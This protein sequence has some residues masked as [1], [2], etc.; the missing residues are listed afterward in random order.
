MTNND[1]FTHMNAASELR[2]ALRSLGRAR[3][4]SIASVL[5]I[6]LGVAAGSMMYVL[7]YGVLFRPLPYPQSDQLVEL[8]HTFPGLG[9][10]LV[11]QAPGT[12][13]SYRRNATLLESI[14]SHTGTINI[15]FGDPV[16]G[17]QRV[18]ISSV[19]PSL[20]PMLRVRPLTGR[21]FRDSDVPSDNRSDYM[22][23]SERFWRSRLAADPNV[24]GK[25]FRVGD[26]DRTVIGVLP[27]AFQ[28]PSAEV[29][30][31]FP[32]E[33][34]PGAYLGAFGFQAIG[35]MRP[36][37]TLPALQ[38]QL[39][40]ILTHVP[41][42]FP[43]IHAG[44]GTRQALTQARAVPVVHTLLDDTIGDFGRVLAILAAIVATLIIVAMSNLTSLFLARGESRRRELAVRATLG[45]SYRRLAGG[46][47]VETTTLAIIGGILGF[48][49]AV[50]GIGVLRHTSSMSFISASQQAATA[51]SFHGSRRFIRAPRSRLRPSYSRWRS[52]S[53]RAPWAV[54]ASSRT[55]SDE[56]C[57]TAA[58]PELTRVPT[59]V[60]G[61]S[62]WRPK[63]RY[64]SCS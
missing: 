35:R 12:Y 17:A 6:A 11:P 54:G 28:F 53:S 62:S 30:I 36:D 7:I 16:D 19:T 40:Q 41:D 31:W 61:R 5:T 22:I 32:F 27:A 43:E 9:M 2:Y 1:A 56:F 14:A 45:A 24:L 48:A 46:V 49:L 26:A 23:V 37:A 29:E 38:Q 34:R 42:R 57:A 10:K 25:R 33:I 44:L 18:T 51:S 21:L 15:S 3:T 50:I 13:D 60:C 52:G 55:I 63:L 47:L 20:F 4:F 8:W 58:V 64:R 59:I 39:Q